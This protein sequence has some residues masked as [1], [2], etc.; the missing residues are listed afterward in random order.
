[1]RRSRR[2]RSASRDPPPLLPVPRARRVTR[3]LQN[4][5]TAAPLLGRLATFF[6]NC[7]RRRSRSARAR[8]PPASAPPTHDVGRTTRP[9]LETL[10]LWPLLLRNDAPIG[11]PSTTPTRDSSG[12]ADVLAPSSRSA[13]AS[14]RRHPGTGWDSASTSFQREANVH[15]FSIR[16]RYPRAKTREV[17]RH[18]RSRLRRQPSRRSAAC[19]KGRTRRCARQ[20]LQGQAF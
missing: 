12:R 14:V 6:Q 18:W 17:R 4:A 20:L 3:E 19:G 11:R 9:F 16:P 10:S 8:D 13:R 1:M 7:L 5:E 2:G 15:R